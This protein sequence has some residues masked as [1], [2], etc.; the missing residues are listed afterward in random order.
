MAITEFE[1]KPPRII[2][3]RNSRRNEIM[4]IL[5][6]A[7]GVLLSLCLISAAFYPGDPSWNSAGQTETHNWT[8]TIGS[9]V[10]AFL[11]QFVGFAAYL[12][13]CLLLAAAWRRFN[14]RSF[15]A[16]FYR[17][18][19]LVVLTLAAAALLSISNIQPIFDSS[20]QPGGL[21]G[22][23]ISRGLASGLNTVGATVLLIAVAATGLL[24]ATNFSFIGLYETIVEVI[25]E[26]FAVVRN[27]PQKFKAWR[28]AR[29]ERRRLLKEQRDILKAAQLATRTAQ[30]GSLELPLE[31]RIAEYMKESSSTRVNAEAI[32]R[33]ET[34]ILE[35]SAVIEGMA[36]PA[37]AIAASA[38]LQSATVVETRSGRR[39]IFPGS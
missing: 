12:L 37:R 25:V 18:F 23:L 9:N 27:L 15:R 19:G 30:K 1:E 2:T 6:F 39:S 21:V 10:A 32:S 26:R 28:Q 22:T 31:E 7:V 4:A 34:R 14:T 17:L 35:A 13:P 11:F 5:L 29:A 33:G 20:V 24:L 38:G 36:E 16:P 3:P 8:G